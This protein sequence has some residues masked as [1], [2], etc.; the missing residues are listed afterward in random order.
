MQTQRTILWVIFSMSLLFLWDA[1][2]RHNGQ[3]SLFGAPPAATS[4]QAPGAAP[5]SKADPTLPQPS[6][7]AVPPA[8]QAPVPGAAAP[9]AAAQPPVRL[10]T[11]VLALDID[12]AGGEVQRAELLKYPDNESGATA[13]LVLF[14]EKPGHVYVAQTGLVGAAGQTLPNHRTPFVVEPGARELAP[15][16]DALVLRMS[17]EQ[18]GVRVERTYTVRRGSYAIE[19]RNEISNRGAEPVRPTLYMQLT[20]DKRPP[21]NVAGIAS[22]FVP[23]GTYGPVVYTDAEKFQKVDFADIDKGGQSHAKSAKDGWIGFMQ[24]YFVSAWVPKQG[25]ERTIETT[26]LDGDLYTVRVRQPLPEIAPGAAT[27][28]EST[29]YVGPQD[30]RVLSELAPGLDLV[31]DYGWLTVIAKPIFELLQFLHGIVKNWGWAIVLL[32]LIIKLAFFPLQ[33]ASYRSMAKMKKVGPKLQQLRER[34][35]DDRVK[36]NQAMMEM[37]KTEKINPLGGCLPIVVQIPVFIALYYVLFASVELRGAPWLGWIRDLASPDPFYILPLLM[38]VS[39]FAQT[40]LNP[41]PPDPLQAKMM[42]WMPLI[43]SVMFF[44][45]PAGL[46]LYWLVNNLFS[47]AQQWVV[48]RRIEGKPV[49]GR[50]AA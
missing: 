35:G 17:A 7:Q 31:V 26:R 37:Y 46:V 49:F 1:W 29:L 38:A 23:I 34:Y 41:T 15:G 45:F 32:T 10:V 25:V 39:M 30:Q 4:Q 48:T 19:V 9:A 11:D 28:A 33:A 8:G 21:S 6:A 44:F 22:T 18:G 43:F 40:K 20:R 27:T 16:A 5:A 13:N 47:I 36:L 12:P 2:Q 42:M 50:A 24:H 14:E 3:P